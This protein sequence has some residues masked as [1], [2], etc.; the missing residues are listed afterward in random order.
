MKTLSWTGFL[1]F[2]LPVA[3]AAQTTTRQ[4]EPILISGD[5]LASSENGSNSIATGI[6]RSIIEQQPTARN[7]GDVINRMPGVYMGGPPNEN[8]DIRLRGL[9]KEFTRFELDGAQLP[10]A[11]EKREFQVNRLSPFSIGEITILRNPTA[12]YE[13]DGIAGRILA[14]S[15]EIP[16]DQATQARVFGGGADSLDGEARGI[17]LFHGQRVNQQFGFNLFAD[18]EEQPLTKE[19]TVEKYDSSGVL[20]ETETEVEE[21]PTETVNLLAD[22][23]WFYDQGEVHFRPLYNRLNEDKDKEKIKTKLDKNEIEIEQEQED[24]IQTTRG[25]QLEHVHRFS[26]QV[27]LTSGLQYYE[28]LEEK[29]KTKPKFKVANG[30]RELDKTEVEDE[31]K[32]DD[33][34]QLDAGLKIPFFSVMPQS[35][36]TGIRVR[37][38]NRFRDKSKIE[39]KPD[40]S[41]QDKGEAKDNYELEERYYAAYLQNDFM[42][43]ERLTVTPGVR[44]ERVERTSESGAGD[45]VEKTFND[46]NPHLHV[47]YRLTDQLTAFGALSRTINM[48]K[49]DEVSP[50][51]QEK[52]DR[53]TLGNPALEPARSVNTDLGLRW[54]QDGTELVATVFHKR[55]TDVIEEVNTGR[56]RDGKD[57]YQVENV[58]DGRLDGLELELRVA[59]ALP[60][61]TP[62]GNITF[63][64][65]ELTDASGNKRPFNEQPDR[66]ANLG[67]D[68][69][70]A[71]T[72][73]SLTVAGKYVGDFSKTEPDKKETQA[74]QWF[75]DVGLRQRLTDGFYVTFDAL[76]ILD[77]EK[78]KVKFE[79]DDTV[80]ERESTGPVYLVG[81]EATF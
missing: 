52:G 19:K 5:R 22:L 4:L 9:D 81:L 20:K 63:I 69:Q 51:A 54:Q 65:S 39:I 67:F 29:D 24:K 73:T 10:G 75:L 13:S 47:R 14:E 48:P 15:R 60:G 38:R 49:F 21:K 62:W 44:Y 43:T 17:N 6:D 46:V 70:L 25:A 55:I 76:N 8:K 40:G 35:L 23:A 12:K 36:E 11:G 59:D 7:L 78:E 71:A 45:L 56:V 74:S 31:E 32:Q 57:V 50:Y 41:S 16:Q 72:G 26:N 66:I 34:L 3:V 33:I 42:A 28:T 77:T 80:F 64:H 79:G 53:F 2:A 1:F 58:G 30:S 18:Y 27:S 68:Y 61:L 37:E